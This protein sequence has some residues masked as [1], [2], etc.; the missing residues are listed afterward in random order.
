MKI[1]A[2]E[3]GRKENGPGDKEESEEGVRV[4][5]QEDKKIKVDTRRAD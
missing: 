1:Q 3:E 5:K 4:D 2:K